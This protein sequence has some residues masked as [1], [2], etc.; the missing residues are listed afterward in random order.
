MG[1]AARE[2][3][4]PWILY[5]NNITTTRAFALCFR[6]QGGIM[7]LGGVNTTIHNSNTTYVE[8]KDN[9]KGFYAVYLHDIL[10]RNPKDNSTTTIGVSPTHLNTGKGVIIDSG[11][12]DTYFPLK[13]KSN[14]QKLF[15]KITSLHYS[16]GATVHKAKLVSHLL[17]SIIYRFQGKDGNPVD[18]ERPW[19]SYT[20]VTNDG[21]V[22]FRIYIKE[23]TGAV[24]GANFMNNMNVIFDIDR[25]VIGMASSHC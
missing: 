10:L 12:T 15:F 1:L 5:E 20:E 25:K 21:F 16:S 2:G 4:L 23:Q 22:A 14:F 18:I 24:L 17:P 19:N 9:S 6:D 3:G 8:L 7:S 13:I 11:T